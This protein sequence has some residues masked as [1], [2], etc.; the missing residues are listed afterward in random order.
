M[1]KNAHISAVGNLQ[2]SVVGIL[3]LPVFFKKRRRRQS[4]C[5]F[6]VIWPLV[7]YTLKSSFNVV[8]RNGHKQTKVQKLTLY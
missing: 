6:Y 7:N 2:F 8:S 3:Q 1:L 5:V 4:A